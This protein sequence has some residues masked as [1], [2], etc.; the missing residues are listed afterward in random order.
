MVGF[1]EESR[2]INVKSERS[3]CVGIRRGMRRHDDV[4]NYVRR[5]GMR[6]R[7]GWSNRNWPGSTWAS[8]SIKHTSLPCVRHPLLS[9]SHQGGTGA[10]KP[11]GD[12]CEV[13]PKRIP[14][15]SWDAIARTEPRS[16]SRWERCAVT[17]NWP[18]TRQSMR[19]TRTAARGDCSPS[20]PTYPG[21][22]STAA[23]GGDRP[24]CDHRQ[25]TTRG[26]A[27]DGGVTG[28]HWS[29]GDNW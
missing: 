27:A 3:A 25:R 5:A 1:A 28:S 4:S 23:T 22:R 18:S 7:S 21:R 19:G 13:D 6:R 17:P 14:T 10:R 11:D 12:T 20:S 8:L 26:S 9:R 24:R 16:S 15:T 29:V 2:S